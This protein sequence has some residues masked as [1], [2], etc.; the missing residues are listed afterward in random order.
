MFFPGHNDAAEQPSLAAAAALNDKKLCQ[1]SIA[2]AAGYSD[3]FGR[4]RSH[5]SAR[6]TPPRADLRVSVLRALRLSRSSPCH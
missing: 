5:F 6:H 2:A 3:W 4:W 1:T